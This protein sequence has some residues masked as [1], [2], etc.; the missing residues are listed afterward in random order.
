MPGVSKML[1]TRHTIKESARPLRVI[2]AEDNRVN[3]KLITSMLKK[4]GFD[5]E[6]AANGQEAIDLLKKKA[7]DLVLMDMQ[8]P[9]MDG[10]QATR[11]IRKL[12]AKNNQHT[13]IFALTASDDPVEIQGAINAGVDEVM[14]KPLNLLASK[15]ILKKYLQDN[16]TV[17]IEG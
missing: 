12:D 5:V 9:I 15:D 14:R 4:E 10:F 1:I 13:L 16:K 7:A 8:M 11:E 6:V 17:V 3:Q 2:V